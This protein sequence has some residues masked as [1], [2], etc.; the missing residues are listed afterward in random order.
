[1][2]D[3]EGSFQ[4]NGAFGQYVLAMPK[5]DALVAVYSGSANLFAHGTLGA[6]IRRLFSE[7]SPTE[8]PADPEAYASLQRKLSKLRFE[9]PVPAGLGTDP[10]EFRRIAEQL[11][12]R[13][14]VLDNNTGG[15]FPQTLQSVHGNYTAGTDMVRFQKRAEGLL[16]YF[17]EH[18]ERNAL[19]LRADGGIADGWAIMKG[20]AQLTGTRALWKLAP[21]EIR[22]FVLCSFL[23]TPDTRMLTVEIRQNRMRIV[24]EE[25]PSLDRVVDMLFE[26]VGISQVA[27]L[28]R[29]LPEMRREHVE[30]LVRSMTVPVAE[31]YRIKQNDQ[32]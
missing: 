5:Y 20:E 19:L 30:N 17:Y 12:G 26:L 18:D 16:V 3:D 9:P 22:L 27:Y 29:M 32:V 31:G 6:H 1:M 4:F 25:R 15:L 11:D 8:L 2:A 24:F 14:Y 21:G 28:K 23:E 10:E 7:V 13:E